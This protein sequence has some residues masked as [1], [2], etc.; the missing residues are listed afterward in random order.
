MAHDFKAYPELTNSQMD[1]YYFESPHKQITENFM[2]KVEKVTDGDTV[3]VSC[4]FRDF[5]F[6]IRISDLAPPEL[7]E[8][9]RESQKWLENRLLGE[10]VEVIVSK[11]R[12]E[13]WGRLLA[14]I[15][16]FGE[17]MS[18]AVVMNGH[19][20][21]WENRDQNQV[22]GNFEKEMIFQ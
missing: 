14:D 22:F 10:E 13:K 4:D 3:R 9:G 8:G 15:R 5:N 16:H 17:L 11:A 18:E 19:G 21:S 20:V 12:V 6:P 2:A 7:N 1:V